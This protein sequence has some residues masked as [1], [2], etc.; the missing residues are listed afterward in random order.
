MMRIQRAFLWA[1]AAGLL[2]TLCGCDRQSD[3]PAARAQAAATDRAKEFYKSFLRNTPSN[4]AVWGLR[5]FRI[6]GPA[7]DVPKV[8]LLSEG[9]FGV[10]YTFWVRGATSS[11]D[12]VKRLRTLSLEVVSAKPGAWYVQ[13]AE[14]TG[15]SSLSASTEL[16]AFLLTLGGVLLLSLMSRVCIF[17]A[18]IPHIGQALVYPCVVLLSAL[19]FGPVFKQSGDLR[20]VFLLLAGVTLGCVW[21]FVETGKAPWSGVILAFACGTAVWAMFGTLIG[22][23]VCTVLLQ[24]VP[25]LLFSA[26][27]EQERRRKPAYADTNDEMARLLKQYQGGSVQSPQSD[28]SDW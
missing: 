15:E 17:V 20:M 21:G 28:L 19:T 5:G 9:R 26:T 2:L 24:I 18:S 22:G 3:D 27:A 16:G 13:K 4:E 6:F 12:T 7:P 10:D 25:L 11:G 1:A 14:F 8:Q 23:I